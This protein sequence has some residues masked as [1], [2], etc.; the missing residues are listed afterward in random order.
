M[1]LASFSPETQGSRRDARCE[2]IGMEDLAAAVL[3]VGRGA[4][5]ELTPLD[6]VPDC[7]HR[8]LS[9]FVSQ[10]SSRGIRNSS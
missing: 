1:A 5:V 8:G 2:V 10:L 3:R 6:G 4:V 7:L 9:C